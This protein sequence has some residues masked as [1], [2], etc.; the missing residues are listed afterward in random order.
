MANVSDLDLPIALRRTPRLCV[1]A[2]AA[3]LGQSRL[4]FTLEQGPPIVQTPGKSRPRKRVRFSDPGPE[5][6]HHGKADSSLSTGLTPMMTRSSLGESSS[7]RRRSSATPA[8]PLAS[9]DIQEDA[10]APPTKT[11]KLRVRKANSA[12]KAKRDAEIEHLQAELANRDAEIERLWNGTIIHDTGRIIELERQVETLHAALAQQK[13]QQKEQQQ[14]EQQQLPPMIIEDED[15]DED[16]HG[17]GNATHVNR[18]DIPLD[19]FYD[20]TLDGAFNYSDEDDDSE[21]V[22]MG[23]VVCSTPSRR[24]KSSKSAAP[25]SVSASFPT[26]PCTSPTRPGTPCSM[27]S[28]NNIPIAPCHV[29]VQASL[30]DPE[31][32]TLE[33][34]LA[35]LHLELAKMTDTLEAHSQLQTRLSAKLSGAVTAPP[36]AEEGK[37]SQLEQLEEHLNLVL[38]QLQER[39]VALLE[40]DL[41]LSTLGFEGSE[42]DDVITSITRALRAARLEIEYLMPGESTLP[43]SSRGAEVLDLVLKCIR[44]LSRKLTDKESEI[45]QYH[46]LELSLRQQLAARVDAM[47]HMRSGEAARTADAVRERDARIEELEFGLERLK[48]AAAGY[49]EDIAELEALVQRVDEEGRAAEANLLT[50][51]TSAQ[52]EL[53]ERVSVIGDLDAKL[54]VSLKHAAE[55]EIKLAE[56]QRQKAAEAKVRNK[57]YGAA[58]AMRDGRVLELRREIYGINES[59]RNAHD[60]ITALHR[61][62]VGLAQRVEEAEEGARLAKEAM[63]KMKAELEKVKAPAI[64]MPPPPAP[65]RRVTRSS[66]AA[67]RSKEM[68]TPESRSVKD[69]KRRKYDSGVGM[70]SEDEI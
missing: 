39:T 13:Q 45:D 21:D 24:E 20:W 2:S 57:S 46:A 17:H 6:S 14:L 61:E 28:V 1:S 58:L 25:R 68:A 19:T 29:G 37:D 38:E 67:N 43:L 51:L 23:D 55:L 26:P 32:Q 3:Q 42:P 12:A 41:S 11:T 54:V 15:G 53:A 70:M 59:L 47:A 31:N 18:E 56:L 50:D 48:G 52:A 49:R 22:T 30:P 35:S 7:K 4:A 36:V 9:G 33:A 66:S 44:D 27:R 64:R 40:L 16:G 10:P 5:L 34:E 60:L 8:I 63:D 69:K 65:S 62:N